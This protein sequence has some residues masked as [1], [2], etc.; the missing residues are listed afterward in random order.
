MKRDPQELRRMTRRFEESI[1]RAGV[2]LTPQRLE[3]FREVAGTG[4][5]PDIETIYRNIRRKMPT[6]SLDTVYRTLA[7]FTDLGLVKTVRPLNERVRFDA[8]LDVHHHFVCSRC[9]AMLDFADPRFD[10]IEIPRAAAQLGRVESRHLELRGICADCL[11][12]SR[13]RRPVA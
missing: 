13:E 2:K 1:R 4:D 9:G 10:T 3:I 5:H 6:V 12:K 8:N 11:K 7:L